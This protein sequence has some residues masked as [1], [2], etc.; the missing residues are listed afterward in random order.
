MIMPTC[1]ATLQGLSTQLDSRHPR[2][3]HL[4]P[5]HGTR[6]AQLTWMSST[7]STDGVD[8]IEVMGS[9]QKEGVVNVSSSGPSW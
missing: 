6:A 7:P 8:S 2:S 3:T 4:D 1:S 9:D 5:S